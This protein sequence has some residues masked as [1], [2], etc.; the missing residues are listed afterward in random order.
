MFNR[1]VINELRKTQELIKT[2]TD[3]V[4][5]STSSTATRLN[6]IYTHID[7]M[8][9]PKDDGYSMNPKEPQ[10]KLHFPNKAVN[11]PGWG[12]L[13]NS[14]SDF[15]PKYDIGKAIAIPTRVWLKHRLDYGVT[16]LLGYICPPSNQPGY[17]VDT[18]DVVVIDRKGNPKRYNL[19]HFAREYPYFY[20]MSVV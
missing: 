18:A 6:T 16:H 11:R 4:K 13:S 2:L 5:T 12:T 19:E 15:N 14:E 3:T 9:P 17:P 1:E 10:V 8:L 7:E 20:R